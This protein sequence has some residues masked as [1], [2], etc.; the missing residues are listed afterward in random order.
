MD[1]VLFGEAQSRIVVSVAEGDV[2]W[3]AD[4][5]RAAEVPLARIGIVGGRDLALG[6][7]LRVTVQ[8]M[9]EA[10]RGGLSVG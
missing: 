3:L 5:A 6:N 10:W 7:D 2:G 1:A 4:A 9:D 8:R